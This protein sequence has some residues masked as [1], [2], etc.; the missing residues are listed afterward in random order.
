M[1]STA[2]LILTALLIS[3]PPKPIEVAPQPKQA[4][5]APPVYTIPPGEGV[6]QVFTA[7]QLS[8]AKDALNYGHRTMDTESAWKVTKGKT[9][10]GRK[11]KVGIVDTGAASRHRDLRGQIVKSVSFIPGESSEDGNGHGSHVASLLGAAENNWG[12]VGIA[13]E[14]E[15]F[16]YKGLSNAGGSSGHSVTNCVREAIKDDVDLLN[17]SLGSRGMDRAMAAAIA[18][19]IKA[20]IV[21]VAAAGND[22]PGEGTVNFPGALPGVFCIGSHNE[23]NQVSIFGGR[24]RQLFLIGFGESPVGAIPGPGDGLFSP[25]AGTSMASPI[26]AGGLALG[27]TQLEHLPKAERPG[28]LEKLAVQAA[29]DFPPTGRDTASGF[30]KLNAARLVKLCQE[31]RPTPKPPE[32]PTPPKPMPGEQV[33]WS[34]GK[35]E[36]IVR[37]VKQP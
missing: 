1:T 27:L 34:D 2:A 6:I 13:P 9:P 19:A 15:L 7:K 12:V 20:G 30:G 4:E 25:M 23:R 5:E 33:I 31:T 14:V 21:V 18:D 17:M 16:I 26:V 11:L 10:S 35:I 22:G 24:G 36:I 8:E 32:P 37:I 29:N 3:D 28:I